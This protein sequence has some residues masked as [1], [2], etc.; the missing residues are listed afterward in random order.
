M[1]TIITGKPITQVQLERIGIKSEVKDLGFK[2]D[3]TTK[4]G[5][6]I[7]EALEII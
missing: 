3:G 1:L 7:D 6:A 5:L 2:V 4:T